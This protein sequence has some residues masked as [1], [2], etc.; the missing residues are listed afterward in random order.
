MYETDLRSLQSSVSVDLYPS[1]N[2]FT[3]QGNG[4]G[5]APGMTLSLTF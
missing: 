3:T 5:V 4:V 1:L 2:A